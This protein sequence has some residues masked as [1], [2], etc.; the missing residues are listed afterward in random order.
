M[1]EKG[2]RGVFIW[3]RREK[4]AKGE[5]WREKARAQKER[6]PD[7]NAFLLVYKKFLICSYGVHN[8]GL[9]Y[10]RSRQ[11]PTNKNH[12]LSGGLKNENH[13]KKQRKNNKRTN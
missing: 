7:K 8:Q 10:N 9:Q 4:G 11:E 5:I 1:R 3:S 2:R 6:K 13:D 12:I